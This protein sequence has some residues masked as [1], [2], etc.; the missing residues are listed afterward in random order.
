MLSLRSERSADDP[1][2][3]ELDS[4]LR[5]IV[6]QHASSTTALCMTYGVGREHDPEGYE[7]LAHLSEH[8][9]FAPM[10]RLGD[11]FADYVGGHGV[12]DTNGVTH[13]RFSE[14]C[15]VLPVGALPHVLFAEG[16][17]GDLSAESLRWNAAALEL[18][19]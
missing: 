11:G 10:A 2:R 13:A 7:G 6:K 3:W 16:S 12:F 5:V 4:G 15:S 9:M 8:L 1:A 17:V 19:D 18:A 14:Y